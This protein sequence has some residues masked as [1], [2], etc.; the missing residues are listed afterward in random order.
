MSDKNDDL[1]RYTQLVEKIKELETE[2]LELRLKLLE[3][4]T[5]STADYSC[6]VKP[7]CKETVAS[8]SDVAKASTKLLLQ[9]QALDLIRTSEYST[10]SVQPKQKKAA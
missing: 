3:R 5:H 1:K 9:L 2:R 7:S 4:G 8:V 6:V 10:V